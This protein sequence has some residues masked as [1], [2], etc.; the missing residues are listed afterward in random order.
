MEETRAT[1]DVHGGRGTNN[2]MEETIIQ[3][4]NITTDCESCVQLCWRP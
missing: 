1:R 3:C 2:L 4:I